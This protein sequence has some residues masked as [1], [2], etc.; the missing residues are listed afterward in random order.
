MNLAGATAAAIDRDARNSASVAMSSLS[1]ST[2]PALLKAWSGQYRGRLQSFFRTRGVDAADCEDLAQ[3][4]FL[5]LA[6]QPELSGVRQVDA[7]LYRVAA[8]VLTDWHRRRHVRGAGL[9]DPISI[10]SELADEAATQERIAIG[11]DAL[12]RLKARLRRAPERTQTIFAL[13]HFDGLTYTEIAQ[14]CGIAVRTVEDH[15]ARA[16]LLLLAAFEEGQ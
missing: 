7:Y 10:G 15:M 3:E 16:N 2:N 9:H 5:R 6:Q 14:R 4:V 8:N 1:P 12:A 11:R 13:H